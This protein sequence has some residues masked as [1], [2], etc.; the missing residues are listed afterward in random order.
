MWQSSSVPSLC[1]IY[2]VYQEHNS[3][4]LTGALG[5]A[6]ACTRAQR[7]SS[8]PARTFQSVSGTSL[9]I[10]LQLLGLFGKVIQQR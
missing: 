5:D 9:V 7:S 8:K 1:G 4:E 2:D 6:V 10:C 3:T